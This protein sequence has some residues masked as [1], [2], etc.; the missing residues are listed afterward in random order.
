M[1]TLMGRVTDEP[2]G[3]EIHNQ[4]QQFQRDLT[5]QHGYIIGNLHD[6]NGTG[7]PLDGKSDRIMHRNLASAGT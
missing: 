5:N 1:L 4:I 6:V 3:L 2:T 7:T